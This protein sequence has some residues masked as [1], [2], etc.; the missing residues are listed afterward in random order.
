[1]CRRNVFWGWVLMAFGLGIFFGTCLEAGFWCSCGTML[2]IGA[3]FF[4][5]RRK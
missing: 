3:G 1:M 4:T 5:L 2:I